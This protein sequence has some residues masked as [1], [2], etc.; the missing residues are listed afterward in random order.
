M[1]KKRDPP[2]NER[3]PSFFDTLL[4]VESIGRLLVFL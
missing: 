3:F 2:Y 1:P 4:R